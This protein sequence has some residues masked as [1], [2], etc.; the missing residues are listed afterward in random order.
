MVASRIPNC[1]QGIDNIKGLLRIKVIIVPRGIEFYKSINEVFEAELA[2][3]L[4]SAAV[5]LYDNKFLLKSIIVVCLKIL[6]ICKIEKISI[7]L[8]FPYLFFERFSMLRFLN[9]A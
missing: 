9:R 6:N 5:M 2:C 3:T 4:R 8:N 1:H 7:M